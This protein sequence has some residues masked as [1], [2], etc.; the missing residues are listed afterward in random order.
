MEAVLGKNAGENMKKYCWYHIL[1]WGL[2]LGLALS[3]NAQMR[4]DHYAVTTSVISGGGAPTASGRYDMNAVLGQPSPLESNPPAQSAYAYDLYPGFWYTLEAGL[5]IGCAWDLEPVVPDGDV[6]GSDLAAF[7]FGFAFGDYDGN[8][9]ADFAEE[10]GTA[11][12]F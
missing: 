5:P 12:C 7:A 11:H 4:S 1:F 3:A 2:I 8:E 9:L 6:D 10:F